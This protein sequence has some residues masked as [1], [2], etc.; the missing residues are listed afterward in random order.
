MTPKQRVLNKHPEAHY[1]VFCH[2]IVKGT[3]TSHHRPQNL[4]C[5][6]RYWINAARSLK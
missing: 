6:G 5:R 1:C 3:K 2:G 4:L